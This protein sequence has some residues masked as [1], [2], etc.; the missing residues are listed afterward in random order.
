MT[1]A[2]RKR[3]ERWARTSLERLLVGW[4]G[5]LISGTDANIPA[6]TRW[7]AREACT[8]ARAALQR[9]VAPQEVVLNIIAP[10]FVVPGDEAGK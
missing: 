2:Q 9:G 3:A 4:Q 10:V 8:A 7:R 6:D 5:A 1:A